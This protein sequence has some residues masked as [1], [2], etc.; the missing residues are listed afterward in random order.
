[1]S[2]T[3][4]TQADQALSRTPDHEIAPFF[5]ER[6]SSRSFSVEEIPDAVLFQLFEAA[7]WA[8]SGGNRQPWRFVYAKRGSAAWPVFVDLLNERNRVW[9]SKAAALVFVVSQSLI[10]RDGELAPVPN[11]AFDA[12]A[13]WLSLALQATLLGWNTRAMGGIDRQR[14]KVTLEVPDNFWVNIAIAIGKRGV[15]DGL[16][17]EFHAGEIPNPRRPLAEIVAEGRF[18][19]G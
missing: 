13:A 17:E 1:M 4:A 10:E 11:H 9:A 14:A 19:Q 7:R 6:W 16:P 18:P 15:K 3:F 2:T 8:P 5:W 12:G